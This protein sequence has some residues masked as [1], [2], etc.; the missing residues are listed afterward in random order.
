[1]T[2]TEHSPSRTDSQTRHGLPMVALLFILATA[3]SAMAQDAQI[4]ARRHQ[5]AGRAFNPGDSTEGAAPSTTAR[6]WLDTQASGAMASPHK[7]TLNGPAM[8]RVYQ[9][10]LQQLSGKGNAS[11]DATTDTDADSKNNPASDLLK[12]LSALKP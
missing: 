6:T 1:M 8:S 7:Q 5:V 11:G 4:D 3:T 2:P 9:R 10:L 12:G